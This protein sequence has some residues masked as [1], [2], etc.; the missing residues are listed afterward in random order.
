MKFYEKIIGLNKNAPSD[1]LI[2][3]FSNN[4]FEF[5]RNIYLNGENAIYFRNSQTAITDLDYLHLRF[6]GNSK[7]LEF[8][9]SDQSGFSGGVIHA[10][11]WSLGSLDNPLKNIHSTNGY[12]TNLY[13]TNGYFTNIE[14]LSNNYL[15]LKAGGAE[16]TFDQDAVGL[17]GHLTVNGDITA[18]NLSGT[19][20][21]KQS[22]LNTFGDV[23]EAFLSPNTLS[24]TSLLTISA[25]GLLRTRVVAAKNLNNIITIYYIG[26]GEI[27]YNSGGTFDDT[28]N[29]WT[30][31]YL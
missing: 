20:T 17:L 30:R 8:D 18:T 23:Y 7:E 13:S 27:R 2:I 4:G 9:F 24:I 14:A 25:G 10:Y 21:P 26:S 15:K 19:I 1:E 6:N 11:N 12:F 29:T 3:T 16:M 28:S 5:N 31:Y 22:T